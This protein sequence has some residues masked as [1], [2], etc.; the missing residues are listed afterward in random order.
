M[1]GIGNNK[2]IENKKDTGNKNDIKNKNDIVYVPSTDYDILKV[3]H[4][5][6]KN[7]TSEEFL[8]L[9]QPEYSI[10]SCGKNNRYGHPHKELR[11]RLKQIKSEV[12][13]T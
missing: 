7:S 6:S 3:A 8:K 1:K 9:I 2:D 11:D 5:G 13:I 12:E 4:H 10:I